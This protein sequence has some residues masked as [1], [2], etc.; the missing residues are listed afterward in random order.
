MLDAYALLK[1][2]LDNRGDLFRHDARLRK[3]RSFISIAIDARNSVAHFFGEMAAREGCAIS[4]P[5]GSEIIEELYD[6]QRAANG[7]QAAAESEVLFLGK[8]PAPARLRPWRQVCEPR[9]DVLEAR[10]SD[11]EFSANLALV[12]QGE[13]SED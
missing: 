8:T 13:G 11:A 4:T 1:T 2:L 3:A 12:D 9:P 10:F 6:D 7:T 5:C